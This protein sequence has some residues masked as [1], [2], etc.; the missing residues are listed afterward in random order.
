MYTEAG[1]Y[2]SHVNL[3]SILILDVAG[4]ESVAD[5]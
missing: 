3:N 2:P 5:V 1:H 4:E